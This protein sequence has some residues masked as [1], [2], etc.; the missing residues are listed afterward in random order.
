M[1]TPSK[2]TVVLQEDDL[3]E[4]FA[5]IWTAARKDPTWPAT[6]VRAGSQR[7]DSANNGFSLG[8]II[9]NEDGV[10]RT[11]FVRQKS[12]SADFDLSRFLLVNLK[13]P[14]ALG[15][16]RCRVRDIADKI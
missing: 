15:A 6:W 3:R 11:L 12:M 7:N 14:K 4:G 13:L 9:N 16:A 5:P 1:T 10:S 8:I 2:N